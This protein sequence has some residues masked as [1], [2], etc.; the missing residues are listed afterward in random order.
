[1]AEL[2]TPLMENVAQETPTTIEPSIQS[3]THYNDQSSLTPVINNEITSASSCNKTDDLLFD[4]DYNTDQTP[5][6]IEIQFKKDEIPIKSILKKSGRRIKPNLVPTV[7]RTKSV[8]DKDLSATSE[9]LNEPIELIEDPP[10]PETQNTSVPGTASATEENSQNIVTEVCTSRR[11]KLDNYKIPKLLKE[12]DNLPVTSKQSESSQVLKNIFGVKFGQIDYKIPKKPVADE[13][14]NPT[15]VQVVIK[16]KNDQP[17]DSASTDKTECSDN[18]NQKVLEVKEFFEQPLPPKPVSQNLEKTP[19][20]R[21]KR[22]RTITSGSDASENDVEHTKRACLRSNSAQKEDKP[23]KEGP[24]IAAR[25][26][27][28][29]VKS[30]EPILKPD[31][32]STLKN[33]INLS[34]QVKTRNDIQDKSFNLEPLTGKVDENLSIDKPN[35]ADNVEQ[36]QNEVDIPKQSDALNIILETQSD[37]PGIEPRDDEINKKIVEEPESKSKAI[38]VEPEVPKKSLPESRKISEIT[39]SDDKIDDQPS[40]APIPKNSPKQ[41]TDKVVAETIRLQEKY[42]RNKNSKQNLDF[43]DD[44]LDQRK[45]FKKR[46]LLKRKAAFVAAES[47]DSEHSDT[48]VR[49]ARRLRLEHKEPVKSSS[50]RKPGGANNGTIIEPS[51]PEKSRTRKGRDSLTSVPVEQPLRRHAAKIADENRRKIEKKSKRRPRA[52]DSSSDS[53]C[54]DKEMN[55]AFEIVKITSGLLAEQSLSD[56]KPKRGVGRPKRARVEEPLEKDVDG[57]KKPRARISSH[58]SIDETNSGRATESDNTSEDEP[59]KKRKSIRNGS[60][61]PDLPLSE[62]KDGTHEKSSQ[63][64]KVTIPKDCYECGACN[65]FILKKEWKTHLFNHAGLAWR[66]GLDPDFDLN[67]ENNCLNIM[68]KYR[69]TNNLKFLKCPKCQVEERKSAEGIISH[70]RTCGMSASEIESAKVVCPHCNKKYTKDSLVVHIRSHCPVLKAQE[71]KAIEEEKKRKEIEKK[72]LASAPVEFSGSGRVKRK[73]VKVAE[74]KLEASLK[75]STFVPEEHVEPKIK[76]VTATIMNI[77]RNC[78]EQSFEINCLYDICEYKSKSCKEALEHNQTCGFIQE[79]VC[80]VCKY[81]SRTRVDVLD[82]I[83]KEHQNLDSQS[84]FS[85]ESDTDVSLIKTEIE[86]TDEDESEGFSEQFT[87]SFTTEGEFED[88]D[89]KISKKKKRLGDRAVQ[90]M[91]DKTGLQSQQLLLYRNSK[92]WF[93]LF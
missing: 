1:M 61:S 93:S 41:N 12:G 20:V 70:L 48:S 36:V 32:P 46:K 5:L 47:S 33:R 76:L 23:E 90:M 73:S 31:K 89:I 56:T 30:L 15:P 72:E 25:T 16:E 45:S 77:W 79:F 64:K 71:K 69:M 83:T 29:S 21:G 37:S 86:M 75:S 4:D 92:Y 10:Q 50:K 2:T 65:E 14:S 53:N 27:R 26:R 54:D 42:D 39:T 13:V 17:C 82:H 87:D 66:V 84:E 7:T 24:N 91:R 60:S 51:V 62:L 49:N 40:I 9:T 28:S 57:F 18:N 19:L 3:P 63:L 74:I 59:L 68:R 78:E 85:A 11:S 43:E 52:I 88:N 55:K 81:E 38:E 8:A 34:K 67:D 6:K 22:K 35:N 80:I 58:D 44:K